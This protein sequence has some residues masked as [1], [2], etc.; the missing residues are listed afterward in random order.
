MGGNEGK[1][2]VHAVAPL[3]GRE[4]ARER[5]PSWRIGNST[6]WGRYGHP[7]GRAEHAPGRCVGHLSSPIGLCCE[8]PAPRGGL[9]LKKERAGLIHWMDARGTASEAAVRGRDA[10]GLSSSPNLKEST[11][12]KR[13]RRLR[14]LLLK[15]FQ[16]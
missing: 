15:D 11:P 1:R 16:P 4:G 9:S 3:A 12:K 14:F 6:G 10:E 2:I 13:S 5:A 8:E 7:M